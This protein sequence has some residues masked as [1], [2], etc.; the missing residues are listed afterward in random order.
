MDF[1]QINNYKLRMFSAQSSA[2]FRGYTRNRRAVSTKSAH[3][4]NLPLDVP[5]EQQKPSNNGKPYFP[6]SAKVLSPTRNTQI[7]K[8]D[9]SEAP[10]W[11][12]KSEPSSNDYRSEYLFRNRTRSFLHKSAKTDSGITKSMPYLVPRTVTSSKATNKVAPLSPDPVRHKS[13]QKIVKA[14][15]HSAIPPSLTQETAPREKGQFDEIVLTGSGKA[16]G[17]VSAPVSL[18]SSKALASRERVQVCRTKD[19]KEKN[20]ECIRLDKTGLRVFPEIG[21]GES[22][23]LK[24]LSLQHNLITRLDGV[25]LLSQLVVLDLYDNRV[26]RITGLQGLLSLRVLLLGKNRYDATLVSFSSKV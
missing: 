26:E 24:M 8:P 16:P 1:S 13:A 15:P 25:P 5:S 22:A 17:I 10:L 11:K 20:P 7:H 18:S 3:L 21:G 19:E 12:W 14:K 4:T 23:T 6:Y 2:G 9:Q